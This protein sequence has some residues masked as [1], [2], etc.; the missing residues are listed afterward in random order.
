MTLLPVDALAATHPRAESANDEL[1]VRTAPR[2]A[3]AANL[4]PRQPR[5][6][7]PVTS[8]T[9]GLAV[10]SAA[11]TFKL[12]AARLRALEELAGNVER[13]MGDAYQA[14]AGHFEA[15]IADARAEVESLK[16]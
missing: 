2:L 14:V 3:V 5:F 7:A 11:S 1:P 13:D 4:P 16:A 9:A 8:N 12:A 6:A 10:P 15:Q